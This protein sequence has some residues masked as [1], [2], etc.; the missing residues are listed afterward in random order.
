MRRRDTGNFLLLFRAGESHRPT[1]GLVTRS[2]QLLYDVS[3]LDQ[4]PP[5]A[6]SP[7]RN[8]INRRRRDHR[9]LLSDVA[10]DGRVS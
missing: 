7:A 5:L 3:G 4:P 8:I 10:L 1:A 6:R 9:S 2:R